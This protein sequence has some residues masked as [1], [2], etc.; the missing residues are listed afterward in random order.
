MT[1]LPSLLALEPTTDD[2]REA[3]A[4]SGWDGDMSAASVAAGVFNVWSRHIA[5]RALEPRLGEEL[6]RRYHVDREVFQCEVLPALLRDPAGWLDDDLLRAA[7]ADA[8]A[9][10]RERWVRIPSAWRWG[11]L[12]RVALVHP[13]GSIPGLEGSS[14]PRSTRSAATS[15]R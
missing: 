5:R 4:C 11:A 13:L 15:R 9:E 14:R 8:L 12:H 7:L 2:E 10:L 3:L 1:A 6:F